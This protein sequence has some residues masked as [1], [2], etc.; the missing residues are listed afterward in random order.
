ME[1]LQLPSISFFPSSHPP[2]PLHPLSSFCPFLPP[3]C[4]PA[5][6][7]LSL[8]FSSF[9][10]SF[11][12][13]AWNSLDARQDGTLSITKLR[14][15]VEILHRMNNPLGSSLFCDEFKMRVARIEL[16]ED[17]LPGRE[18]SFRKTLRVLSLHVTGP[19][20]LPYREK[21]IQEE[22]IARLTQ[23]SEE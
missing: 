21:L 13:S 16:M 2:S 17:G 14:N 1:A 23:V 6:L 5:C 3:A 22:K 18:M 20:A 10:V 8:A 4:L 15:L 9:S 19:Q 11:L 7:S 12:Q